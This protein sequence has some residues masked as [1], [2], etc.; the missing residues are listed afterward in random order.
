MTSIQHYKVGIIPLSQ[1]ILQ[2]MERN[3][4][5]LKSLTLLVQEKEDVESQMESFQKDLAK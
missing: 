1:D 4:S 3:N 2:A 5:K